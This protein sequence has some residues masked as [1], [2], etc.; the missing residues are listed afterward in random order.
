MRSIKY[1]LIIWSA[2]LL[3]ES[4]TD[5]KCYSDT[6]SMVEAG[7]NVQDEA[8]DTTSF[9]DSLSVYSSKWND[10]IHYSASD[11][12]NISFMLSPTSDTSEIIFTSKT[13]S[14]K[15]TVFFYYHREIVFISPECGF[16]TNF[17]IVSVKHTYNN[18]D[19][20]NITKPEI[21]V[22]QNGQIEIYF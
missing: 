19:S 16:G 6:E 11:N 21:L 10:S 8:L 2:V 15:D 18:I 12:P 4:C 3:L 5:D 20:I 14:L 13:I 7:L 1:I 9:L 17:N 22:E